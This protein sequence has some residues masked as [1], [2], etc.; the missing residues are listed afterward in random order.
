MY[1]WYKEIENGF[2]YE[3]PEDD[4]Q[5][6]QYLYGGYKTCLRNFFYRFL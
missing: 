3:L 1:P 5:A 2:D 4:K 6:I